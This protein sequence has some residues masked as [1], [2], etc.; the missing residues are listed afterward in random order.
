MNAT[1]FPFLPSIW[2]MLKGFFRNRKAHG[3][4]ERL[5]LCN[6]SAGGF[7]SCVAASIRHGCVLKQREI[8]D[9]ITFVTGAHLVKG[10]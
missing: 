4:D 6:E 7:L 9:L 10:T 3:L 2:Y 1:D 5:D 8:H